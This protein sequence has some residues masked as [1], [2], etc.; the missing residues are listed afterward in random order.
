MKYDTYGGA[1]TK[2]IEAGAGI[3]TSLRNRSFARHTV[4]VT[5]K[6]DPNNNLF[7]DFVHCLH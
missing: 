1:D 5:T 2:S 7:D 6:D 3:A 4:H